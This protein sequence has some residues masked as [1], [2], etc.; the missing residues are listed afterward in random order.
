MMTPEPRLSERRSR[1]PKESSS[2]KKY[3]KNGSFENGALRVRTTCSDEM[4][5]TPLIVCAA[6]LVKSGPPTTVAGIVAT[7]GAVAAGMGDG[8]GAGSG[9]S[10]AC[11]AFAGRASVAARMRSVTT[12][13]AM[14][15]A[16]ISTRDSVRR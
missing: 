2:P 16:T 8:R 3:R 15:P 11:G 9:W 7:A 4:L 13:P 6:T 12:V 10:T 1:E 14:K 5:A